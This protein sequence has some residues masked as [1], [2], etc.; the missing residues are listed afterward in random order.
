MEIA[1]KIHHVRPSSLTHIF[2][3]LAHLA[4]WAGLYVASAVVFVTQISGVAADLPWRTLCFGLLLATCTAAGVYLV[5]RVKLSDRWLDPADRQAQPARMIF[6]TSQARAVRMLAIG[7]LMIATVA[8]A[9]IAP[10]LVA[11]PW[12]ALT[13][14]LL[15]AGKPR[16]TYP[17]PK[18]IVLLKNIYV[19]MG[20]SGFAGLIVIVSA[21]WASTGAA[22]LGADFTRLTS[23]IGAT[24]LLAMRVLADAILCDIDDE[25]SDRAHGT[26]TLPTHVGRE[27]AW[28]VAMLLRLLSAI[29]LASTPI[30][31]LRTRVAWAGVTVASSLL[32]RAI[33]PRK[34]RDWVDTRFFLEAISV[35]V[36]DAAFTLI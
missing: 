3:V 23:V 36:I 34:V 6:L 12:L 33:H 1:V 26:G 29:V 30:F 18:D 13:G 20:I 32:L 8:A 4:L 24:A 11:I 28:R 27:R 22:T 2:T 15:Y 19:A 10:V 16:S 21:C 14:V 35:Q 25:V 31:A 9:Q 5:D 17:R 7:L